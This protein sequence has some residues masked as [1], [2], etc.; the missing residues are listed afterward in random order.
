MPDDVPRPS[1]RAALDLD[2]LVCRTASGAQVPFPPASDREAWRAVDPVSRHTILD[3]AAH[4]SRQPWPEL[5]VSARLEFSRS[6][7]RRAFEAPYF[8]RRRRLVLLALAL[9]LGEERYADQV[10]DGIGLLVEEVSWCLPAHDSPPGEPLRLL[11]DPAR[12]V[13]DLFAAE[14]AATLTWVSWLHAARLSDTPGLLTQV[15]MAVLDRVIRPFMDEGRNWWWFGAGMNWNPWIVSNVLT[16]TAL[17]APGE[18]VARPAYAAALESLDGYLERTPSD[19]GCAEGIM[20]WWQSAAR[21][22]EALD[23]LG[24]VDPG[25]T[26][27][28][29]TAP[30]VQRMASYPLVVHLGGPWSASVADGIARVPPPTEE[31]DKD[32]HPPA[33]LHRFATA[34]RVPEV[35]ALAASFDRALVPYQAMYRCLVTLFDPGWTQ[36]ARTTEPAATPH[37]LDQTQVF[38]ASTDDARVRVVAKGG[39]NDEPHNHLDVGSVVVAVDGA[40]ILIDVGAGQYTAGSFGPD[41]YSTWF[42]QSGFHTVPAPDGA[43]QGVGERFRAVV[44]EQSAAHVR[45]EL[46]GAYPT[47]VGI[48]SWQREVRLGAALELTDC[49][50]PATSDT[51]VHLMLAHAPQDN[52]DG[53]LDVCDTD[54]RRRA[55]LEIGDQVEAAVETIDL[56]DPIL[57]AVWGDQI[58][59]LVLRPTEIGSEASLRVVL[60][61]L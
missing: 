36:S 5:T 35:A 22:Y 47:S 25:G 27:A 40:P 58:A 10:L 46:A 44:L 14:T 30:L 56:T 11:P 55:R 41:R 9:A 43:E 60:R 18:D 24:W 21:L 20:Y 4:L 52:G 32:Q 48:T 13:L 45:L 59:R 26:T 6:G 38:A 53:S 3:H 33:L 15:R 7:S 1:L 8:A 23:V 17:L 50:T 54:G 31:L 42:T 57:K 2:R 51:R 19:G 61:A 37:W 29:L 49:W 34:A 16:A 12:P 39:H 28:V